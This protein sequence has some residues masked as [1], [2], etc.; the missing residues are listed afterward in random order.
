MNTFLRNLR[1]KPLVSHLRCTVTRPLCSVV[2]KAS[3]FVSKGENFIVRDYPR[4]EGFFSV[5]VNSMYDF[6]VTK[7]ADDPFKT[8]L[9]GSYFVGSCRG[10][11]CLWK[12]DNEI[13][14][15]IF[16][17]NPA[18]RKI[19]KLPIADILI[20][21]NLIGSSVVGFGY[22]EVGDDL[23]VV[24]TADSQLAGI[25]VSVYSLKNNS[26]TRA[27]TL[28]TR[29]VGY[30]G[31]FA[32]G[33]LYWLGGD[34]NIVAFDLGVHR[35]AEIP[36]PDGVDKTSKNGRGVIGFNGCLG[37][38]DHSP[39][40][41]TDIWLM[42]NRVENSWSKLLSLDHSGLL[43]SS[44]IVRPITF[45]KT[46]KEI[47]LR[48]DA[49]KLVWYDCESKKVKNV[50]LHGFPHPFDLLLHN[51]SLVSYDSEL[52]V[53]NSEEYEEKQKKKAL[54]D[55]FKESGIKCDIQKL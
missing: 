10:L 35:H 53:K 16:L 46:R 37:F 21:R 6:S 43:G 30:F 24:R 11:V 32:N 49:E 26:W 51:E 41:C 47:L 13:R 4:G 22:D 38:I 48:L 25:M 18:T 50:T 33:S 39:G 23:K 45:S 27:E 3:S 20:P 52:D 2:D 28:S 44:E 31:V 7:I 36:F 14:D 12:P 5:N 55:Y 15:D 40:S 9:S 8:C 34:K 17:W 29:L 19:K 54:S 42:N 1:V